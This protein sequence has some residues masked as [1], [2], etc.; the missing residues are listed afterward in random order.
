MVPVLP[1]RGKGYAVKQGVF[2]SSGKLILMADADAATDINDLPEL[3]KRLTPTCN[4]I[5]GSRAHMEE[6]SKAERSIPRSCLMHMFHFC[7]AFTFCITHRPTSVR[8]TQ[9]G[10]KL[11]TREAA[12]RTF[13]N[14]H[15]ER[16][17]FD[18]ELVC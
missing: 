10:F 1:N 4:I 7:V 9:C 13:S 11:F 12:L 2:A 8:D 6:S 15:L 14:I 16:W 17:A 18:V 5:C 3:E